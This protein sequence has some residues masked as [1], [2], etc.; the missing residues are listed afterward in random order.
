MSTHL[1]TASTA[2]AGIHTS[3]LAHVH[4]DGHDLIKHSRVVSD[5]LEMLGEI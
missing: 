4:F 5:H 3:L 2:F 1:R